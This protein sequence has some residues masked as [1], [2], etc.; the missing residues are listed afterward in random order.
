[1]IK[2][3][4]GF[5]VSWLLP[6]AKE[7][8]IVMLEISTFFDE[9]GTHDDGLLVVA[10]A[11]ADFVDWGT[12]C[13]DWDDISE[14]FKLE[15]PFHMKEFW[16]PHS[17]IFGHLSAKQRTELM[18]KITK[19]IRTYVRHQIFL[20]VSQ[21]EYRQLSS[22]GIRSIFGTAYTFLVQLTLLWVHQWAYDH[23]HTDPIHYMWEEGHRN[24]AQA[25]RKIHLLATR[26][27][28]SQWKDMCRIGAYGL[29][30]KRDMV[31]LQV[32]DILAHNYYRQKMRKRNFMRSL[33][34]QQSYAKKHFGPRAYNDLMKEFMAGG[35]PFARRKEE[36]P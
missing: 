36:R 3:N 13:L 5:P 29:G 10:G 20:S 7:N 31:P 33:L 21:R 27:E 18:G 23:Q 12:L 8:L 24:A 35:S 14:E 2:A 16:N 28:L 22:H 11:I 26:P 4:I 15:H 1:M 30:S 32:A 25:I 19:T 34:F 6:K 17:K 9:S